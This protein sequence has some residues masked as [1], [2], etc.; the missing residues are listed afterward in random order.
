MSMIKNVV[1]II[2]EI[3][4]KRVPVLCGFGL[5]VLY[6]VSQPRKMW[7]DSAFS[8]LLFPTYGIAPLS[9]VL[10][11]LALYI[12]NK[13]SNGLFR[14]ILF[15]LAYAVYIAFGFNLAGAVFSG[16]GFI[17]M[18]MS[19]LLLDFFDRVENVPY[20][21]I[22]FL[23]G[24]SLFAVSFMCVRFAYI[25]ESAVRDPRAEN[26]AKVKK[27]LIAWGI[28]VVSCVSLVALAANVIVIG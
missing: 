22:L 16:A 7:S 21:F 9:L 14:W 27:S 26:I 1:S 25:S 4:Q 2:E 11:G 12:V 18:V 13:G 8:S 23:G 15:M 28:V 5:A 3:W 10:L 19:E 20:W 24:F 17:W 6:I